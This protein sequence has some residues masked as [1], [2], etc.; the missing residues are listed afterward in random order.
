MKI[1]IERIFKDLFYQPRLVRSLK[2]HKAY[3]PPQQVQIEI[4]N[5]CNL[6]C[7]MCDRWKWI[8]DEA[9]AQSLTTKELCHLFDELS[10]VGVK[11]ILL[12]GGE[13]LIREDFCT[14][15]EY[16]SR[17]KIQTCIFTNGTL[18][19]AQKAAVLVAANATVF[20]SIDGVSKTH[21]IIRGVPSAYE[22]AMEGVRTILSARK[23]NHSTCHVLINFTVQKA[24]VKDIVPIFEVANEL[25]VDTVTYNL[26]HGKPDVVPNEKELSS[27]REE[28]C[29]LKATYGSSK[30]RFR[31]GDILC[32]SLEG[33]IPQEDISAGLPALALFKREPVPCFATYTSSFIDSFGRVFPCCYCY[34]D[35]F[36]F[37][38]FE[39]DRKRFYLGN[40]LQTSFD[41]I[42]Y[43]AKYDEFRTHTDPI[44]ADQL[45]FFCGQCY[46]Y[47][48]FKKL[49][50]KFPFMRFMRHRTVRSPLARE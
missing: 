12:T 39:E 14:I 49:L 30:T 43:G 25:G 46:D 15:I 5:K 47:S 8:K 9:A 11:K 26:V 10:K 40:V 35:N 33:E 20:F 27:V 18:M 3:A 31:V 50:R 7:V 44:D 4:T 1:T 42:W 41:K 36:S 29:R 6:R 37:T 23:E 2:N 34:L 32:S 17:L 16:L 48:S 28:F 22:K 19:N 45:S 38:E 13:P 21:D 24:N